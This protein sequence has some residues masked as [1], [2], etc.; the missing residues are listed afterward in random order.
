MPAKKGQKFKHYPE[1]L[2]IEAVRLFIEEGWCYRK[3]AE[4]L[5]IQDKDRVRVWVRKYRA[6]GQ[7]AFEDRR[8]DPHRTEI[9]QE[10]ELRRL[11]MEVDVLK[12]WLQI[13]N[14]EGCRIDMLPST[15]LNISKP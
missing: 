9:E 6:E 2:K 4:H 8:G 14:R 15:N 3:I 5:E 13:L 11:Q 7:A 10:R 1:S 12:K